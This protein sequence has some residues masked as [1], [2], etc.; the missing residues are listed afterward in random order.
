MLWTFQA[1]LP[2][3]G[4]RDPEVNLAGKWSVLQ[5]S[6]HLCL[7]H[8]KAKSWVGKAGWLHLPPLTRPMSTM[9]KTF[10]CQLLCRRTKTITNTKTNK[11]QIQIH[12]PPLTRP[13]CTWPRHFFA[14]YFVFVQIRLQ[15]QRQI[16]IQI[17]LPPLT[18][19]VCT[20][21]KTFLCQILCLRSQMS[22]L[23][24]VVVRTQGQEELWGLRIIPLLVQMSCIQFC[25]V[26][27]Q[28]H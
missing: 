10:L 16:Q 25:N 6:A 13:I 20:L 12:L 14:Q 23:A 17:H 9:A 21:A 27:V 11:I 4:S 2:F 24:L 8:E 15:I 1:N 3:V 28:F 7:K 19:P 26:S 5:P 18:R 22:H